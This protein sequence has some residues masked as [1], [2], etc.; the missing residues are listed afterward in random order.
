MAPPESKLQ[1]TMSLFSSCCA[2]REVLKAFPYTSFSMRSTSSSSISPEPSVSI[3]IKSGYPIYRIPPRVLEDL[4]DNYVPH[5]DRYHSINRY[6]SFWREA[7]IYWSTNWPSRNSFGKSSGA[8]SN[9]VNKKLYMSIKAKIKRSI[10]GRRWGAYDSGR[11]VREYKAKGGKYSGGKGKTDL[12]RW[13]K[14]KWVDACAWPKK[15]SCGRK[16]AAK[17]AYCRPSKRVDSKTPK[18]VQSLSKAQI[19]SRCTK[20]KRSPIFSLI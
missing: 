1:C 12:G 4:R 19:K 7:H 11:L 6:H 13:Y 5:L 9:V 16:T 10:K 15:K 8:P 20:K 2:T 17:I 14:E 3:L 18:L